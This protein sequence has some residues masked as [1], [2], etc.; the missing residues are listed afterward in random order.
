MIRLDKTS[1]NKNNA[2]AN[3]HVK[4]QVAIAATQPQ[5]NRPLAKE[6]LQLQEMANTSARVKQLKA[7]QDIADNRPQANHPV[8]KMEKGAAVVQLLYTGD[9]EDFDKTLQPLDVEALRGLNVEVLGKRITKGGNAGIWHGMHQGKKVAI[10]G[11]DEGR[12]SAEKEY[13]MMLA[14]PEGTTA[15]PIGQV[16]CL[17][18]MELIEGTPGHLVAK[19]DLALSLEI[20]A[21]VTIQTAALHQKAIAHGDI[22]PKNIILNGEGRTR[23]IDF[24]NAREIPKDKT[25]VDE[26]SYGGDLRMIGRLLVTLTETSEE[27]EAPNEYAKELEEVRGYGEA[28]SALDKE[29]GQDAILAVIRDL[30]V[31]IKKVKAMVHEKQSAKAK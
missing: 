17:I 10:K 21:D 30:L 2:V 8:Q 14:A 11:L 25:K 15:R 28:L 3:S 24:G 19:G 16:G 9:R 5:G 18:V 7:Y 4:Q 1:G 27:D 13:A 6:Q 23:L 22:K 26:A 20:I 31:L 12:A 29:V